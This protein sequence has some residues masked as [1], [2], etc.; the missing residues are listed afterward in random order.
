MDMKELK[1]EW[2]K[3]FKL[4]FKVFL[5][6][7]AIFVVFLAT[8]V[9]VMLVITLIISVGSIAAGILDKFSK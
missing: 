9:P 3:S 8:T 4:G 2:K 5:W 7:M 1:E 6:M